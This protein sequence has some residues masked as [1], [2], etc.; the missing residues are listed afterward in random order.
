MR[1]DIYKRAEHSGR[2]SYL[3]V[4]EGALIPEEATNSDWEAVKCSVDFDEHDDTLVNFAIEH[5]L[6]QIHDKG[7]A[8]TSIKELQQQ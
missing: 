4:P 8:I 3:A 5:P 2:Y 1:L 7:Y 6:Q